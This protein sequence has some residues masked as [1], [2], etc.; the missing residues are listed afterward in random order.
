VLHDEVGEMGLGTDI[1]E[2]SERSPGAC[3]HSVPVDDLDAVD[4]GP[5]A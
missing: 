4:L 3:S 1:D 5:H 2:D